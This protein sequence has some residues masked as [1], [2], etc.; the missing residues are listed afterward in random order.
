MPGA[1]VAE[2]NAVVASLRVVLK[3][4]RLDHRVG[5]PFALVPLPIPRR[6]LLGELLRSASATI[7]TDRDA[8]REDVGA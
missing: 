8:E 4:G 2:A 3:A 5:A 7:G 6:L 1:D